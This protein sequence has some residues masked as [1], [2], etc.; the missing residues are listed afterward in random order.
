MTQAI[1]IK[2]LEAPCTP[3]SQIIKVLKKYIYWGADTSLARPTF[4]CILIDG[5]NISSDASLVI[6]INSNII[7]PIMIINRIYKHQ[8]LLHCS[9]LP[10]WL[11]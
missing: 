3:C 4:R 9:L 1:D 10:S 6:H 2:F 5:E 8:N 11:G 7:S